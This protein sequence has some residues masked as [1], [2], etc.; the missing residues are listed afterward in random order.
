ML[1]DALFLCL[2]DVMLLLPSNVRVNAAGI[3]TYAG[4]GTSCARWSNHFLVDDH[5]AN[6][7]LYIAEPFDPDRCLESCLNHTLSSATGNCTAF[8][9]YDRPH[10]MDG[11]PAN[12]MLTELPVHMLTPVVHAAPEEGEDY[13]DEAFAISMAMCNEQNW[14]REAYARVFGAL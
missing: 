7:S 9:A 8:T 12:C 3:T 4:N 6:V 2:R 5:S 1:R 14:T 10:Q 11:Y 13:E